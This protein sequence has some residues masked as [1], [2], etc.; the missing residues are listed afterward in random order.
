MRIA[1]LVLAAHLV[2][3][4]AVNAPAQPVTSPD[5]DDIRALIARG[6]LPQL[7]HPDF[8][9]LRP[10][11]DD[12]YADAHYAPQWLAGSERSRAGLA[13]LSATPE[14][15]LEAQDYGVDWLDG[16]VRAITGGDRTPAR[17]AR[18]DVALTVSFFR[19][20]S[21]LH[22][23]RVAPARAGF[24][25]SPG[26][27]PLDQAAL[28]RN[29]LV[30][31]RLHDAVIAAEPSFFLYHRLEVAL[32][33][34]RAL[35]NTPVPPLPAL[36]PGTRK[37]E[38]GGVYAGAA[39][40]GERLRLVGDL[41][42]SAELPGGDRYD[43]AL[44][45]A[46]RAFQERHGLKPDGVLGRDTL[47]ELATGF[48]A[49]VR[50]IELSLERLRWLPEF[51][52]GPLIAVNIPSFRLWAFA[53]AR[54]D[55]QAQLTM[56]VIVGRAVKARETPVFIGEMRYVEF[57]PYWNVPPTIQRGE[58]VPRLAR[59][60]G[61]WEREDLEAVSAGANSPAITTLDAAT[62]QG[63]Q[64]G[65][66]RVRQRPGAKNA[67][68]GVKFVLPNTLD[69]Y[70]HSTP[71]QQLFEQSRRDFSHGCIRV[72]DPPALAAFVLRDQPEWTDER[73]RA[74]MVAGKT[75]TV[76]LSQPIPV[77]I[78]YTTAIV[79]SAGRVLFHVGHLRLRS[80]PGAGTA[81]PLAL[82][83]SCRPPVGVTSGGRGRCRC[84]RNP[85]RERD[86]SPPRRHAAITPH[87]AGRRARCRPGGCRS[88]APAGA[89]SAPRP[90][91]PP[92]AAW[93]WSPA[94]GT[95]R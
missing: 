41:P 62:L 91:A 43:G 35:A 65:A 14:H 81:R 20:L 1:R 74:A 63:L 6:T 84:A 2:V 73:I 50:Q 25:F 59:D 71:A 26:D 27:K 51:P 16:E 18:A 58:I 23:G 8:S 13:E 24:K 72:A 69:I 7:R 47:A 88:P 30:A 19:L 17:V 87:R 67:L 32:V 42:A 56:P 48:D 79:D 44:V 93:R 9:D 22:R 21:D 85:T 45:A 86:R 64:S 57:S 92:G 68:G 90:R 34:Y 5:G 54:N 31:G 12:F 77:V 36:P 82:R 52:A 53:D 60:P 83:G 33:R 37:V 78:F 40:L 66:L 95:R 75:S 46:V 55:N 3:L 39:A 4:P 10:A 11:L 80:Q 38:P 49:R 61:Y 15:G 28:L 70:L 94:S 76:N 89:G 29:A